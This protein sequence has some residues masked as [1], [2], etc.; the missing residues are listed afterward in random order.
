MRNNRGPK[1]EPRG[2]PDSIKEKYEHDPLRTTRC[3]LLCR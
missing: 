2:T 3:S 1:T